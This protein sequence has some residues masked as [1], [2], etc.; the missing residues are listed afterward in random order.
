MSNIYNKS[1]ERNWCFWEKISSF[2]SAFST[3]LLFSTWIDTIDRMEPLPVSKRI[4]F[5]LVL[6]NFSSEEVHEIPPAERSIIFGERKEGMRLGDAAVELIYVRSEQVCSMDWNKHRQCLSFNSCG[7]NKCE[8][9]SDDV[10]STTTGVAKLVDS[11]YF[12]MYLLW[13]DEKRWAWLSRIWT[14]R[15]FQYSQRQMQNKHKRINREWVPWETAIMNTA[16]EFWKK[17]TPLNL[18]YCTMTVC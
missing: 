18:S 7:Y 10:Y 12:G 16:T 17:N 9:N 2:D 3:F 5:L 14:I 6:S 11:T 13:N 1:F 4:L 15:W 8:I